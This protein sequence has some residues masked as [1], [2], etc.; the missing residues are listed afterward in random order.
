MSEETPNTP[1]TDESF[2]TW[3]SNLYT[4]ALV[5]SFF[6]AMA[7]LFIWANDVYGYI[8]DRIFWSIF[9]GIFFG[10]ILCVGFFF[11]IISIRKNLERINEN[12]CAFY[13]LAQQK[14][15]KN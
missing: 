10:I 15:I 5:I 3:L 2:I 4:I 8:P 14:E 7:C 1:K 12:L 6:A 13:K 9:L 11:T